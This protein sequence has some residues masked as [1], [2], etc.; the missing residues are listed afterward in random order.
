MITPTLRDDLEILRTNSREDGSPA[1]LIYDAIRNKYYTLGLTAFKLLKHWIAGQDI[2]SFQKKINK[3]GLEITQSEIS[4]FI[5]FLESNNLIIQPGDKGVSY[6]LMQKK[7]MQ[8]SWFMTLIHHYLFFKFPLFKPDNWLDRT[9][10]HVM[11]L[12]SKKIRY[13]IYSLG[14]VALLL[15]MSKV[16]Q[17]TNTFAYFFSAE[18]FFYY[19]LALIFI[20]SCH[21]LGHAYVAKYYGCRV[22]SIGIAF[23][24]M[25]PFLY[26]DTS[27]AWRLRNHN[28]RLHINFAGII[29]ELHI[30]I[31]SL[32]LWTLLPDGILRSVAYFLATT[33]LVSSI[34]I[35]IS[36]FMRFDGYYIFS[37]WLKAENL[38]ERSF[39]MAKWRIREFLFGLNLSPPEQLNPL[40]RNT[41]ILFAFFTWIYR[42]FLF[43][44]IALLV[45]HFAFKLLGIILFVIE[46]Y[47]FILKPILKEMKQWYTLKDNIRFN[48][49]LLR[50]IILISLGFA[51]LLLPW[52]SNMKIPA[53]YEV[54]NYSKIFTPHPAII[55]KILVENNQEVK[56]GD[57]LL[58]LYSPELEEKI[59]I[60][61]RKII[62]ARKA[63]GSLNL[64]AGNV[65]QYLTTSQAISSLEKNL[66]SLKSLKSKLSITAP[67]SGKIKEFENLSINQWVNN[68]NP[69]M[70]V[71]NY[72]QGQVRGLLDDNQ[73][74]RFKIEKPAKFIPVDGQH[75]SISLVSK[76][77]DLSAI[78][79][80]PY[81]ALS[82]N[83]GGPIAVRNITKGEFKDRP[84]APYY[85]TEFEVKSK[86]KN[87]SLE[88]LGY[89]HMQGSYYS[90][91]T[92]IF[93]KTISI[94]RSESGF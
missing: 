54:K 4:N 93:K 65:D 53:V 84:E 32:F 28:E 60:T 19:V 56:K 87:I 83:H 68:N 92:E 50:T 71:V 5:Y 27:D 36:P 24:V 12:A 10:K 91:F 51:F 63:L 52:K 94:L 16:D 17:F 73:V 76:Q 82:S 45:Y 80:L 59:I 77:V 23:L 8:Q 78:Q 47:W 58:Q 30:A 39:N 15:V 40:R 2:A 25:F 20:K 35:N 37:D 61:I 74:K 38:H 57:V 81:L 6:L 43:L 69:L 86:P 33:S 67:I 26:T 89:V 34:M 85:L 11:F 41:F 42:F 7:M 66:L 64:E 3:E 70:L 55:K 31:I 21:E 49:K 90:P 18:G 75:E 44:G 79:N 88:I 29:T 48:N 62:L 1:W 14:V 13:L 22:H 72:D 46:I 9:L